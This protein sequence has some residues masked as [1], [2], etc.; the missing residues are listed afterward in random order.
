MLAPLDAKLDAA[1]TKIEKYYGSKADTVIS[2]VNTVLTSNNDPMKELSHMASVLSQHDRP[3]VDFPARS[4]AGGAQAPGVDF[5]KLQVETNGGLDVMKSAASSVKVTGSGANLLS[6]ASTSSILT[7]E[8]KSKVIAEARDAAVK[9]FLE[10]T[11]QEG[12]DYIGGD[13]DE[14][15]GDAKPLKTKGPKKTNVLAEDKKKSTKKKKGVALKKKKTSEWDDVE[16]EEDEDEDEED[17]RRSKKKKKHKKR[18]HDDDDDDDEDD[19]P[20]KHKKHK[21]DELTKLFVAGRNVI[22]RV[23]KAFGKAVFGAEDEEEEY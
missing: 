10:E 15:D 16:E 20:K 11:R 5:G 12:K 3:G 7:E 18:R 8:E 2:T 9:H 1:R 23:G 22:M 6:T 21:K 13:D 17:D 14:D 19:A 4:K